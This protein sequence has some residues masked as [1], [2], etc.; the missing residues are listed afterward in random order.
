MPPVK[1]L[2]GLKFGSSKDLQCEKDYSM[3]FSIGLPKKKKISKYF[4]LFI[5]HFI[6]YVYTK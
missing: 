2:P 1:V 5:F 3:D 4:L 6:T